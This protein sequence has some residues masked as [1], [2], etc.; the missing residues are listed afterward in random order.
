M[1]CITVTYIRKVSIPFSLVTV[2][3]CK[4]RKPSR[5]L[6]KYCRIA[7]ASCRVNIYAINSPSPHER[8]GDGS[9]ITAIPK[10]YNRN[11]Y[12]SMIIKQLVHN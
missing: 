1:R 6:C 11:E 9:R 2:S 4:R 5:R 3:T 12:I 7:E 10:I 8:D